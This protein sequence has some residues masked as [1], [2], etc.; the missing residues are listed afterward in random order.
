M[1]D[2]YS[3]A[4]CEDRGDVA[5]RFAAPS[6]IP[7]LE[8]HQPH[9]PP[10]A[11]HPRPLIAPSMTVAPHA[12]PTQ[13]VTP[14][15]SLPE[16]GQ[17]LCPP[18]VQK[19]RAPNVKAR[20]GRG[21][22]TRPP[23]KP[24]FLPRPLPAMQ[25]TIPLSLPS[26]ARKFTQS[27]RGKTNIPVKRSTP[28]AKVVSDKN[29]VTIQRDRLI[30]RGLRNVGRTCYALSTLQVL[31][32]LP[33]F[34]QAV[35]SSDL[36]PGASNFASALKF[37]FEAMANPYEQGIF[38]PVHLR[39]FVNSCGYKLGQ[40]QDAADFL[41]L[42][43]SHLA[44]DI[45]SFD[46]RGMTVARETNCPKCSRNGFE[47]EDGWWFQVTSVGNNVS[48]L[49]DIMYE[50]MDLFFET[51]PCCEDAKIDY[52]FLK[53]PNSLLFGIERV[54]IAKYGPKDILRERKVTKY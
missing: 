1:D 5:T 28:T 4:L 2:S 27:N 7:F 37:I 50:A 42:V 21:V 33:P 26:S 23:S 53:P 44:K 43:C 18:P 12:V 40:D 11:E 3:S 29:T 34:R 48:S 39:G 30:P 45:P 13:N 54:E 25:Q 41:G 47:A 52:H 16:N 17:P 22:G 51:K 15:C 24:T 35:L 46:A 20:R 32:H 38:D 8:T 10:V 31:F 9:P 36:C 6:P 19:T 49:Q 14:R